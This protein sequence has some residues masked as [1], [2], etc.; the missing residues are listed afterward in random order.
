MQR[1]RIKHL[2][3]YIFPTTV[4]LNSHRLLLRPREGHDVRIETSKLEI[5]PAYNIKG[6]VMC[7]IILWL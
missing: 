7:L 1:L 4:T 3:E 5:N 6:N 2:T